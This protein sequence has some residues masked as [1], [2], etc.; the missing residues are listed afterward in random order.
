MKKI[1]TILLIA[2]TLTANAQQKKVLFLGNSYTSVNGLP[3]LVKNIAL[4]FGDLMTIDQY[5]P[6][7]KQL[8][9]HVN[10]PTTLSKIA[11]QNWDNVVIQE[12]S[13]LPSFSP[14]QVAWQVYPHAET[15][16]DSIRSNYSC[17]E[18]VFYMIVLVEDLSSREL[19][20]TGKSN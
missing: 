7:G 8:N 2:G 10:D 6:G 4:S 19:I 12:Q 5:T 9:Q 16:C 11:S 13:Q 17:S 20:A 3:T 15:L 18:P 14:G 1:L